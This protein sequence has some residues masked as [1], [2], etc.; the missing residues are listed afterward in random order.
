MDRKT[1]LTV[2]KLGGSVITVKEKAFTPDTK[3]IN[4]LA[5]EVAKSGVAPIVIVHGGGSFGH[6]V[7]KEY[8]IFEG[9]K[10]QS[11]RVGF[12]K[13]RQAMTALNSLI[14]EALVGKGIAAVSL[15]PSACILTESGRILRFETAPLEKML[16]L[17]FAPIMYGDAVLDAKRGFTILSG[18]Q[19][20]SK[21]AV[22]LEATR[23]VIGLD[24]DGLYTADPKV[25]PKAELIETITLRELRLLLSKVGGSRAV[26]VTGGMSGKMSEMI[27]ALEKGIPVEM[28]NAKEAGRLF[29]ALKGEEVI[30][31]KFQLG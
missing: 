11:Q 28:V 24:V 12:S 17:G 7:A 3:T 10:T 22:S 15:Q 6:I 9:Y 14:V 25:D 23:I 8:E 27:P 2:L 18:D 29:K 31:T 1:A 19:I 4:R 16:V 13:T 26:D 21:L 30:G 20:V 5:E